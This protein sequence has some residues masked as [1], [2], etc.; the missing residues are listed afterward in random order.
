MK[1]PIKFRHL[2]IGSLK[3]DLK[4]K[5]TTFLL[6]VS[7]FQVNA[8][9]YSQNTKI[10]L[11]MTQVSVESVLDEIESLT[12]FKFFIDTK[13]IDLKR[14]VDVREKR[15]RI[16]SIIKRL[17]SGRKVTYEIFN[18]QIILKKE[19]GDFLANLDNP[20]KNTVI[21]QNSIT[22]TITDQDG[23]PLPGASVVEKG[24]NNGTQSDFDGNF[25]IS[26]AD[27]NAVLVV[28]YIG[29]ATKE[30]SVNGQTQLT[31]SLDESASDLEEV[32]VVGYG[33]QKK[34]DLT[35]SIG[36]IKAEELQN[37]ASSNL[38]QAL[39][40]L[41]PGLN[42]VTR[43]PG[44]EQSARIR[45]RG[46]QSITASNAPLIVLDGS[47][48]GGSLSELPSAD[49][50][51]I[52]VLK[53]ASSTAIYGARGANGVI[54]ITTKKGKSG[55]AKV[56]YSNS[57][58]LIQISHATNLLDGPGFVAA[59]THF[60]EQT[61]EQALSQTE[62]DNYNR[63]VSTDWIDV[64]TRVGTQKE[65]TLSLSGG[66]DTYSYYISGNYLD[67]KGI[68]KNDDF[69][70]YSLR[71]NFETKLASWL[72]FGT[73]TSSTY[74]N[75]DGIAANYSGAFRYNPLIEPYD[76]NGS[77]VRRPWPE[78]N[79]INPLEKLLIDDRNRNFKLYANNYFDVDIP[80]IKGLNYRLNTSLQYGYANRET[81]YG[82]ETETGITSGGKS[83]VRNETR[84]VELI[85]NILT[86]KREFGD[87]NL[88]LTGLYSG[89]VNKHKRR[90]IYSE[91]FPSDVL[92]TYQAASGALIE[93]SSFFVKSNLESMMF[94]ANYG[95]KGKYLLTATV[96]RD[97]FSAFGANKKHGTFP[98]IAM[99]WNVAE[100][101]FLKNNSWLD[102]LKFRGTWG[103]SGNQGID[104][105][106][107]LSRLKN[108]DYLA[109]D[110]GT[111]TAVGYIPSKLANNNLGWETTE[112]YNFG[113]DFSLFGGRLGGS[114]DIF[115]SN[116]SDL[117]LNRRIPAVYGIPGENANGDD[118]NQITENI[119][120]VENRGIEVSL[121]TI[122]IRTDN[123][124]WNMNILF[125]RSENKIIDL[126]G[127]GEDDVLN[128]WFIGK[129]IDVYYTYLFDGIF[130]T[131]DDIANSP[132][133]SAQPGFVK[134]KDISGP[135]GVP[136]GI[137]SSDDRT[138]VG[139][140]NPD[141]TFGINSNFTYK[142]LSL[143]LFFQGVS[144]IEK[145][146]DLGNPETTWEYRRNNTDTWDYWT[147]DNPSNTYP[148]NRS[149]V[150]KSP[151]APIFE[152]ASYVRLRDLKINYNLTKAISKTLNVTNCNIYFNVNNAYTWTKWTGV[153]PEV[154]R[155]EDAPIPRIYALGLNITF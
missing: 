67:T 139:Q 155:Q 3:I 123:F 13:K 26:V 45:I 31:I 62:L 53:D 83:E 10:T 105:Y 122:P 85:E 48:W 99:G 142:D 89:Q 50:A 134:V 103:E 14:I 125:D 127:N 79:F 135:D 124:Q 68:V 141:F 40:G 32:V 24:T 72:T 33:T 20:D 121:N 140:V 5:L 128:E 47:I 106:S 95:Y 100:E 102:L 1:K 117:L 81:Y 129:P 98:S 42:I 16:S 104:P 88:Y 4:M 152:N 34:S 114:I 116:V 19:Q 39:Q 112:T 70:R 60:L 101:G 63:G 132:Q 17:F 15:V 7:L 59:K 11:D 21:V 90:Q 148:A 147:P 22:G 131:G 18:K 145:P 107:T 2:S 35:G 25:S 154:R 73:N 137:L 23:Q 61:A 109:G 113:L 12:E 56:S 58:G 120:E 150:N 133:P 94:R 84:N 97:G 36:S 65:H 8:S 149:L 146:N 28:S 44:A 143:N 46:E 82:S 92:T 96:R 43:D 144:G 9:T 80:F 86:Y 41:V 71:I 87:H 77:L 66:S 52:D 6:I 91:G 54:M 138:I 29:F 118:A 93:P 74:R 119:G 51:A 76:E 130:Q 38:V 126:Y 57:F 78:D 37:S 110:T 151:L 115:K 136:D 69:K 30:I 111:T 55:K 153:D 49:I 75:T 27:E 108:L 64:V